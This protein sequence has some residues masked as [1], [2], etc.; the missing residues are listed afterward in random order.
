[1]G[2][3]TQTSLLAPMIPDIIHATIN[4]SVSAL[5]KTFYH[6]F[7]P[8]RKILR[9]S[10]QVPIMM[11]DPFHRR[12][13]IFISSL[14]DKDPASYGRHSTDQVHCHMWNNVKDILLMTAV[15]T[16]S[17]YFTAHERTIRIIIESLSC[18]FVFLRKRHSEIEVEVGSFRRYPPCE[19]I[20]FC[21][22][23]LLVHDW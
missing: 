21:M 9:K 18:S 5:L 12:V 2:C 7:L 15:K 11:A 14:R 23:A 22:V 20:W 8:C 19:T 17:R 16:R 13:R 1:M 3:R 10:S 4:R 6:L